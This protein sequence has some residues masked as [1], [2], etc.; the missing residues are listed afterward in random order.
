MLVIDGSRGEGGGQ[1][2]RTSLSLSLITGTPVRLDHIRAN[3]D[4][5]GLQRQH[6]AAVRAAA[7]IG[8]AEVVGDSLNSSRL[9]FRP[10]KVEPGD[11]E[12]KIGT[13]GSTTLVMQTVLPPLLTASGPSRVAIEGGTHN[14]HAPPFEYVSR[15][16]APLVNRMGPMIEAVLERPGFFPNG[17][18]RCVARIKPGAWKR[19][20]VP[21]R[22]ALTAR[23]ARAI[24]SRLPPDIAQ[25]EL[26]V[27][28]RKLE[29][30]SAT[31]R[32]EQVPEADARGPGNVLLIELGF[33]HVTELFT[34]FGR[35]GVRA[36]DVARGAA[37][38]AAEYLAADA[39]VGRHLADQLLLPMALA[40]SGS[41]RATAWSLHAQTNAD[42]IRDFL[43]VRIRAEETA[44][45]DWR[46]TVEKSVV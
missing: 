5:P 8:R 40:G 36:E 7:E 14:I 13:A 38:E 10:G 20:D 28:R 12:F 24:V 22:G 26:D 17:G 34:G 39:A 2:L 9:D 35:R 25:R 11:Y 41:F 46:V 23:I 3:R 45:N 15:V 42:V 30:K 27:V 4:K 16:Y 29:W 33:E 1:I 21:E 6:L 44:E 37:A 43:P 32:A 18:G 31:L 19:L